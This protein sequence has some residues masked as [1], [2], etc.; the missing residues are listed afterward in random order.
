MSNKVSRSSTFHSGINKRQILANIVF[1]SDILNDIHKFCNGKV[2]P[3]H[4][5][6]VGSLVYVT[7]QTLHCDDDDPWLEQDQQLRLDEHSVI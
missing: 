4:V 7:L 1:D 6:E 2:I 5:K 3:L